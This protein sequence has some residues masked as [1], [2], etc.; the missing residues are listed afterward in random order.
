MPPDVCSDVF[1]TY[2]LKHEPD[3]IHKVP[4]CS[5]KNRHPEFNYKKLHRIEVTDYIL[6]Y[7][8]DGVVSGKR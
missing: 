6:D 7:F 2:A 3:N 5:G 1:V 8:K 4:V